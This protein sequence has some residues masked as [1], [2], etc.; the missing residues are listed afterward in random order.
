[1]PGVAGAAAQTWGPLT[2]PSSREDA[3]GM[4]GGHQ[5]DKEAALSASAGPLSSSLMGLSGWV[6]PRGQLQPQPQAPRTAGAGTPGVRVLRE[7]EDPVLLAG[8][9][10]HH[11]KTSAPIRTPRPSC[12]Q[13]GRPRP[14]TREAHPALRSLHTQQL[15]LRTHTPSRNP[16]LGQEHSPRSIEKAPGAL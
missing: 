16:R 8:V 1:M 3:P 11:S 13:L 7:R 10:R 12:V 4:S 15:T 9:Q 14:H 2:S 6:A 5:Q